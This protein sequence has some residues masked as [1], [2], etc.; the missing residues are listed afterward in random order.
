MSH[1]FDVHKRAKL[2]SEE[3][4][5]LLSPVETLRRLGYHE[6]C[7]FADIGCGT[8]LFT[9]PAAELGGNS[10]KIYAVDISPE[11]LGD[12]RQHAAELGIGNITTV[13]SEP[14]DFKL[15]DGAADYI[16]ICTVLHEIDNKARFIGEAK[17]ICNAGGKIAVIDF[18]EK[19]TGFGPDLSHRLLPGQVVDLLTAAGFRET[20]TLD[21]GDVFYAI[22]GIC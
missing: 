15:E 2:N 9:F 11:M 16:L 5:R 19:E 18:G 17:R 3:R 1:I 8:G 6:G 13:L 10:A 4:R 21:I 22:T 7:V 12:V 14:Y 20:E